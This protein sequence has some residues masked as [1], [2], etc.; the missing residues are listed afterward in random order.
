MQC[1]ISHSRLLKA[2]CGHSCRS[3]SLCAWLGREP[4]TSATDQRLLT[5]LLPTL[6]PR[7]RSIVR[8]MERHASD[9]RLSW[10]WWLL[11]LLAVLHV[12][13]QYTGVQAQHRQGKSFQGILCEVPFLCGPALLLFYS[14]GAMASYNYIPQLLLINVF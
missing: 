7:G 2:H 9:S 1:G 3:V 4:N 13:I 14:V 11:G 12:D 6:E 5:D 10:M 8:R